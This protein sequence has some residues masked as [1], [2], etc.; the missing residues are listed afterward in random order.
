[1]LLLLASCGVNEK[2]YYARDFGVVPGTGEDMTAKIAAAIEV[3]R[4]E[5][6]GKPAVLVLEGGEYDFY[7][8]SAL[9]RE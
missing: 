9:V 7:P 8:D 3:I 2:V 5:R 1:M 6:A 4:S